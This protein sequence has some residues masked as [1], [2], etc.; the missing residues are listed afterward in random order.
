MPFR[1]I[2]SL[3]LSS[4]TIVNKGSSLTIAN[5]GSSLMIVN[6]TASFVKTI[7][8]QN[9]RFVFVY[10]HRFHEETIVFQKKNEN[11]ITHDWTPI[12]SGANGLG[13]QEC[14]QKW[15]GKIY[16]SLLL[17]LCELITLIYFD[18]RH[19][20]EQSKFIWFHSTWI[21]LERS[22]LFGLPSRF[23]WCNL[24]V[25]WTH[26]TG[27]RTNAWSTPEPKN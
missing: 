5:E 20:N 24:F 7:I 26:R 9:D 1:A 10:C 15:E 14:K 12:G 23:A 25:Y 4:L 16:E 11:I 27:I 13:K 2:S 6:E 21:S 18:F 8:L 19:K 17:R 3:L 22:G